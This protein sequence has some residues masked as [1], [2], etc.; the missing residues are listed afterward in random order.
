MLSLT[1]FARGRS[2]SSRPSSPR[3]S[4]RPPLRPNSHIFEHSRASRSI[5]NSPTPSGS[6]ASEDSSLYHSTP[7]LADDPHLPVAGGGSPW[8]AHVPATLIGAGYMNPGIGEQL[9]AT[10]SITASPGAVDSFTP[11][12]FEGPGYGVGGFGTQNTPLELDVSHVS[13]Y[14]PG[15]PLTAEPRT[16]PEV[17]SIFDI[18]ECAMICMVHVSVSEN[19]P[20]IFMVYIQP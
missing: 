7:E 13:G 20:Y 11:G 15:C 3:P 1:E 16:I 10:T 14:F 18:R 6:H 17:T 9:F 5:S 4:L 2:R 12:G 19:S 8:V